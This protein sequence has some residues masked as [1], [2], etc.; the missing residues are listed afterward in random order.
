[1]AFNSGVRSGDGQVVVTYTL[2]TI[3]PTASPSQSPPANANGWNKS[4]VA[5]NWNW[6]DNSDGSGIDPSNCTTSSASSGEGTLTLQATC[7]DLAGN[8][9]NAAYTV[10]VD[11]TAPTIS[12][13]ATTQPNSNGWYNAPVTVHFICSDSLSEIAIG[14]CPTDQIL[15]TEGSAVASTAQTVTD[16]A[17]NSSNLSNV[18][19]A[20]IDKTA[21][22]IVA[23]AT[24]QPNS[25]GWYNANVTVHFICSDSL[26]ELAV[27]ACPTDQILSTEGSAVASTAQTA[28]DLAGNSSN[29]SNVVTAKIDKTAPTVTY[30][31]NAG[32]YSVDQQVQITCAPGDALSGVDSSTCQT[33]S[34]PAYSFGLGKHSYSATATD[35]AGN[36]GNGSTSFTVTITSS[37]LQALINRFC[38][39]PNV[40]ASLDQDAANIAHAPNANAKAGILQGFTQLVQA[41]TGKSLTSDQANLLITLANAL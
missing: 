13:A 15:S 3:A 16:L 20:K 35:K 26:S 14:A 17:G 4:D 11:K 6:S 22:T 40:A 5:I 36:S 38:T 39:D 1:V 7:T 9:G 19:T 23:A 41:Q 33:I 30:S 27:G 8:T 18:V 25:N 29:L 2:D 28:T 32:S 31:G 21:P 24:T 34:A 12:A 37:S 10:K